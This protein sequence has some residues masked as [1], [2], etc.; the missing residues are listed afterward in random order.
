MRGQKVTVI[1]LVNPSLGVFITADGCK[2]INPTRT[3]TSVEIEVK[4]WKNGYEDVFIQAFLAELSK[5]TTTQVA[6][7]D[8]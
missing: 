1:S 4:G 5:I 7:S 3:Y 6:L 2:Y 8:E